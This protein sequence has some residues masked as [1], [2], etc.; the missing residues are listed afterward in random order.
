LNICSNIEF[1]SNK[2]FQDSIND[3]SAKYFE[4]LIRRND[5][6]KLVKLTLTVMIVVLFLAM[7]QLPSLANDNSITVG[8][9]AF[10]IFNIE[11]EK[12]IADDLSITI[13][14]STEPFT[15]AL[16]GDG[17]CKTYGLGI[18]K[19]FNEE[20]FDGGYLGFKY[21][22]SKAEGKFLGIRFMDINQEED[23]Y[24]FSVGYKKVYGSGFTLDASVSA[25]YFPDNEDDKWAPAFKANLGYTW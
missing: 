25:M 17:E 9:G 16:L 14:G 22:R 15:E 7:N 13:S 23:S 6:V 19:Y 2:L 5:Q 18:R 21:L 11:F 4:N 12:K 8:I 20:G 1:Q 10:E 24:L 3:L